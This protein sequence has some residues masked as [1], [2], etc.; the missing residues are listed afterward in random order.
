MQLCPWHG[1]ALGSDGMPHTLSEHSKADA[2]LNVPP[3]PHLC[4]IL[5]KGTWYTELA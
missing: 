4:L 1:R 3:V 2:D 5:G